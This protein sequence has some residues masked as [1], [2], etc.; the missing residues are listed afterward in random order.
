MPKELSG[1]ADEFRE[2][3]NKGIKNI[4]MEMETVI[5]SQSEMKTSI[6]EM[7]S[8]L[9]RITRVDETKNQISDIE[10][11]VTQDTQ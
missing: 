7:K 2:I 4:Q 9:E 1:R 3:F 6:S 8:T 10:D 11:G 5:G